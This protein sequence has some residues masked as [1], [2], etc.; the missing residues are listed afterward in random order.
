MMTPGK[1]RNAI[2]ST[3][4]NAY[5]F[6]YNNPNFSDRVLHVLPDRACT[7][8]LHANAATQEV[9]PLLSMYINSLTL[10]ANSEVFRYDYTHTSVV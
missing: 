4:G 10:A 9:V 8:E 2:C 6:G 3:A 7:D 5:N 1:D